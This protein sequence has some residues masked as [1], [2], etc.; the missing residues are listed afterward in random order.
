MTAWPSSLPIVTR[1]TEPPCKTA[2]TF[3][4]NASPHT[5]AVSVEESLT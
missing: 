5:L 2:L 1:R 4:A 3:S